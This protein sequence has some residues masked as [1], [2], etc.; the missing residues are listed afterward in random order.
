MNVGKKQ[1]RIV[2]SDDDSDGERI[3]NCD[4]CQSAVK[5]REPADDELA[6]LSIHQPLKTPNQMG[7][8]G[9]NP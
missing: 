9:I 2:L 6:I 7:K 1:R 8:R 5:E 4:P 3:N